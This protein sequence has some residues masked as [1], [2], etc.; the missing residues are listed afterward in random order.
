[1]K[2]NRLTGTMPAKLFVMAIGFVLFSV[3]SSKAPDDVKVSLVSMAR[4][5]PSSGSAGPPQPKCPEMLP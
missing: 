3:A 4:R 2:Q 5:W 1:V